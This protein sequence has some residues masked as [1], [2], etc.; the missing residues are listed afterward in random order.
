MSSLLIALV[1]C[2]ALIVDTKNE[3]LAK[4]NN[5]YFRKN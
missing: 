2:S 4:R 1:K 5:V 3:T